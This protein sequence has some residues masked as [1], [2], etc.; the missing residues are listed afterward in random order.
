MIIKN[1]HYTLDN[2]EGTLEFLLCLLQK[3]EIDIYDVPIQNLIRQFIQ[4]FLEGRRGARQGG[5]NLLE[6]PP[7]WSGLKAKHCFPP[8]NRNR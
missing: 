1:D 7:I 8:M 5:L 2:F 6:P 3:E 4:K